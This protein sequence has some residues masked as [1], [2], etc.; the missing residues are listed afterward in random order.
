M[1]KTRLQLLREQVGFCGRSLTLVFL[2][3]YSVLDLN[4]FCLVWVT[5]LISRVR[6]IF[7]ASI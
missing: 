5:V 4:E 7:R 3:F 6:A 2:V 1:H